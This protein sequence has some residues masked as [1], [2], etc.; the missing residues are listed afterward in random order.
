VAPLGLFPCRLVPLLAGKLVESILLWAQVTVVLVGGRTLL[1]AAPWEP[2][3][4]VVV[5]RYRQEAAVLGAGYFSRVVLHQ[6]EAP[7]PFTSLLDLLSAETLLVV[8]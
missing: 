1:P 5:W 8:H 7:A 6:M 4:L 3:V 2:A